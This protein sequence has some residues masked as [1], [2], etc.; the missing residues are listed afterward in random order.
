LDWLAALQNGSTTY[1]NYDAVWLNI[2]P[3]AAER[4]AIMEALEQHNLVLFEND[5]LLSVTEKGKE[6]AEWKKSNPF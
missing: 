2:I 6:Y 3:V 4:K 1:T 5:A